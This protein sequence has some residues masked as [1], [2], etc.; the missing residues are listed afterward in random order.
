MLYFTFYLFVF[1]V[2]SFSPVG[3]TAFNISSTTIRVLWQ[4]VPTE[5]INGVLLGYHVGY[6]RVE[7]GKRSVTMVTVNETSLSVDIRD[8][9][10]FAEYR[11]LV[12]GFNS[13]GDGNQSEIR[14]WTDEDSKNNF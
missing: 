3:L 6:H 9:L 1:A 11:I 7:R 4:P 13:K 2:P 5:H 8:L 14:C 10:K 12:S